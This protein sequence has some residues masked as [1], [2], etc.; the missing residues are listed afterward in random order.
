MAN[1][2]G[3][4]SQE[5]ALSLHDA[6]FVCDALT[7]TVANIHACGSLPSLGDRGRDLGAHFGLNDKVGT[8]RDAHAEAGFDADACRRGRGQRC[9]G[10]NGTCLRD[11]AWCVRTVLDSAD[12]LLASGLGVL[13]IF[14]GDVIAAICVVKFTT[15]IASSKLGG[16]SQTGERRGCTLA[17]G[18]RDLGEVSLVG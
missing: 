17:F 2:G 18:R 9:R 7:G 6:E 12:C 14:R 16:R 3:Y 10:I 13:V 15:I 4:E 8:R 1:V 5:S 11:R